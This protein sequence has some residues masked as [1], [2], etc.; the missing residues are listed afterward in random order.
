M[1]V[2]SAQPLDGQGVKDVVESAEENAGPRECLQ[3][4]RKTCLHG[5]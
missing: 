1:V 2:G 4:G 5:F 3:G